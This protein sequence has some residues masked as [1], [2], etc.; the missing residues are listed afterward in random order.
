MKF[1]LSAFLGRFCSRSDSLTLPL[2]TVGVQTIWPVDLS[3]FSSSSLSSC[4]VV[5]KIASPQMAGVLSPH[6]GNSDFQITPR[7]SVQFS[8]SPVSRLTP[9]P[10]GPRHC[11]QSPATAGPA[12]SRANRESEMLE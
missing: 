3:S 1:L 11:G 6:C 5:T 12:E 8:G 4:W 2:P 7:W 10:S 9:F